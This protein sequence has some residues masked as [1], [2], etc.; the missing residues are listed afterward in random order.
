MEGDPEDQRLG[1]GSSSLWKAFEGFRRIVIFLLGVLCFLKGIL[2]PENAIPQLIIGMI[3]IG[4][5]PIEDLW[6]RPRFRRREQDA[7]DD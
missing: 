4:V 5:L 6:L 3:M 1:S 7:I 2:Y